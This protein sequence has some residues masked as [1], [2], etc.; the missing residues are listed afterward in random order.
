MP[1]LKT[2]KQF[3]D[4]LPPL[5]PEEFAALEAS[6]L[7]EG[8]REPLTVWNGTIIDGHNRYAICSKHG[9][10][11]ETREM[12]FADNEA[13]ADWIDANQLARRNL[14]K[15]AFTLALGRRV[16]RAERKAGNQHTKSASCQNDT[17]Q[18][19]VG[20]I[21]EEHGVSRRTA[22]RAAEKVKEVDADPELQQAVKDHVPV[23]KAKRAKK[24]RERKK[25]PPLPTANKYRV[26]YADPPWEYGNSGVI[27]DDDNWGRAER[28]YPSMS[29][30][31]LCALDVRSL[32]EDNAVLF[33]WVTSP[34]LEDAFPLIKA[35]GF[36]YKQ[37][38]VWD[39]MADNFG[40]YNRTRHEFLLVCTRGGCVPDISK[41]LP[42]SIQSI[43]KSR[44]H[45]EKPE[46][47]RAI[48]DT[49]YTHGN[50]VEL[51]AR[52]ASKGWE[53]WGNEPK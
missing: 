53:V 16:I 23:S 6:I 7:A 15:D 30:A 21:A 36:K 3:S 10:P 18:D 49:M 11:F 43:K 9:L 42:G 32:A 35:W 26:I 27:G 47:F 8:C 45:S 24:K 41:S 34:I 46:E 20:E 22:Y 38:F 1:T 14:T 33:L 2:K 17:G 52:K 4:L 13:A 5:Q 19:T 44:K 39:K 31:E 37:T 51:F 12:V 29:V 25:N 40:H 28:H 48:I 50:R